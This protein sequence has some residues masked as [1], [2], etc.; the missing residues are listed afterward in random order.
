MISHVRKLNNWRILCRDE[1]FQDCMS[2]D[3]S[4][5]IEFFNLNFYIVFGWSDEDI[6][7]SN[8]TSFEN[9]WSL[10]GIDT[11]TMTIDDLKQGIWFLA[12]QT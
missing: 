7:L 5:A 8:M 9:H 1:L 10:Q 2:G 4:K 11:F 6:E 12:E 3:S